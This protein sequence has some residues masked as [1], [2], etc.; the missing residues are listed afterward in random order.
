MNDLLLRL[1]KVSKS[2]GPV[3]AL[4]NIDLQLKPGRTLAI[5]GPNGAG[6]STLLRLVAGLAHPSRGRVEIWGSPVDRSAVG[7]LGHATLLYS[8]LSARE[9]LIFAGR[10]NAVPDPGERADELLAEEGLAAV[11]HRRTGGFSRGM[12]QRLAIAR[13]RVHNPHLLLLDEPF[14]GL[15]VPAVD[16]LSQRLAALRDAGQSWLMVTHEVEQ[17]ATLAR[18]A[19][20]L[21]EGRMAAQLADEELTTASLTAAYRQALEPAP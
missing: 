9:N 1:E 15:D 5:V 3:A 16:R 21:V 4:Q 20:V 11:A 12:A 18:S 13:A 14:T 2:Y 19:A 8:E 7:Y 10:L 17:A 6:K